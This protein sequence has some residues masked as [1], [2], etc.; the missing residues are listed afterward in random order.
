MLRFG[1]F[2]CGAAW[3]PEFGDPEKDVEDFENILKWGLPI[4]IKENDI[5][6][7]LLY[8]RYSPLHNLK[9]PSDSS[10]QYPST[11]LLTADHDDRVVPLHSLKYIAELY[12]CIRDCPFQVSNNELVDWRQIHS[13]IFFY[14]QTNPLLIRVETKAGHGSG[15]PTSKVVWLNL[16]KIM[17]ENN[18]D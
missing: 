2:T 8:F 6:D 10:R 18:E 17:K 12:H 13:L 1:S 14:F 11:L 4:L 7:H 15:K 16:S 3:L 5:A 9:A